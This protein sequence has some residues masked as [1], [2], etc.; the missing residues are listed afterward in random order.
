MKKTVLALLL[1]VG[2]FGSA[3]AQTMYD[4]YSGY[5][6]DTHEDKS[7]DIF[8]CKSQ[9]NMVFG[10]S[11]WRWNNKAA[12]ADPNFS[13][14]LAQLHGFSYTSDYLLPIWGPFG[15][16]FT[17]LDFEFAMGNWDKRKFGYDMPEDYSPTSGFNISMGIGIMP[18]FCLNAGKFSFHAFGGIKG[19]LSFIDGLKGYPINYSD[20]KAKISPITHF[21]YANWAAGVDLLYG[22]VGIRFIYQWGWTNR[23]K[24]NFYDKERE[25][26]NYNPK[27]WSRDQ[28]NPRYD[29]FTIAFI[30]KFD[31]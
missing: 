20:S 9:M 13:G 15:I 4:L 25:A 10:Y 26:H 22:D 5:E 24:D 31:L 7:S 12:A 21:A 17:W 1:F 23:M 14:T 19:Y 8:R 2:V 30:Y 27:D 11:N 18:T 6:L 29:M 28:F 16:S 3:N